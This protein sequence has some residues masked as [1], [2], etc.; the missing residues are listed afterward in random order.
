MYLRILS[1]CILLFS[2]SCGS[3]DSTQESQGTEPDT[4]TNPEKNIEEKI[5]PYGTY[6]STCHD[7][8]VYTSV[9]AYNGI[10]VILQEVYNRDNKTFIQNLFA[11]EDTTCTV[12]LFK[13]TFYSSFNNI[14][15][16]SSKDL[17]TVKL[18]FI[19]STATAGS[20]TVA[21]NWNSNNYMGINTW[22]DRVERDITGKNADGSSFIPEPFSYKIIGLQNSNTQLIQN[23]ST[24]GYPTSLDYGYVFFKHD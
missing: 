14:E 17:Y 8:G 16:N 22:V 7:Y 11:Y 6:Q 23:E 1:I 2:I 20:N 3:N 12:N 9:P 15:Y 13:L 10:G 18:S 4:N 24:S 19:K 21:T 5:F